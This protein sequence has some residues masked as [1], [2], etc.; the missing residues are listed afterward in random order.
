MASAR[1]VVLPKDLKR[2][3]AV[4]L[5]AVLFQDVNTD[6]GIAR[7]RRVDGEDF[8]F[9]IRVARRFPAQR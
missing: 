6:D 9:E 2:I 1:A 5:E 4:P 7:C 3:V 8:A